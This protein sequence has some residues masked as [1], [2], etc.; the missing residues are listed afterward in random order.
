MSCRY[1]N[2]LKADFGRK[3]SSEE[4]NEQFIAIEA[5]MACLEAL[6]AQVGSKD[7]E[8]HNY[9]SINTTLVLDPA[10]GNM[11]KITVEGNVPLDFLNPQEQDPRVIY[12]L[13]E[14]G[15]DGSFT[16][17]AGSAWSTNSHGASITGVPWDSEGLGGNYGAMV[18]C[19]HDGVGWLYMVFARN[20]IDFNAV[21]NITDVYSWR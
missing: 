7:T 6:T 11:Q 2:T 21:A 13:I 4:A 17:P 19:I 9:G 5:A 16:F 1:V 18:T 8:I 3:I 12:L 15:G 10:F 14:D 20:D